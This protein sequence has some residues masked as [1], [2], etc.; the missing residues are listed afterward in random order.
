MY[1]L[2]IVQLMNVINGRGSEKDIDPSVYQGCFDIFSERIIEAWISDEAKDLIRT[3]HGKGYSIFISSNAPA[4]AVR[5][6]LSKNGML[7]YFNDILGR[8]HG[9]KT[10]HLQKIRKDTNCEMIVFI[11]NSPSDFKNDAEIKIAVNV[12]SWEVK[13]FAE[14]GVKTFVYGPLMKGLM[15]EIL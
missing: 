8:E 10:K 11:G 9:S 3:I 1:R 5:Q 13:E 12:T 7:E 14:L 4:D 6:C 2:D 15:R